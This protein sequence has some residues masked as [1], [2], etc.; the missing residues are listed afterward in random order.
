MMDTR[1]DFVETW[2]INEMPEGLG[3]FETFD[4]LQYNI[5]DRIEH[6]SKVDVLSNDNLHVIKGQTVSLYW[7]E[8]DAKEIVIGVEL[9]KK[10]Q[11]LVVQITGKNPK[12][13]GN[14]PFASDLY[15]RIL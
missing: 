13:R 15:N 5:K 9:S 10:P 3:S 4:Q 8:N 14:P 11:G 7:Y 1:I 12:Y 6:G 2:L